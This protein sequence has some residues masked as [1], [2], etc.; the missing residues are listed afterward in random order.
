R[1]ARVIDLTHAPLAEWGDDHEVRDRVPCFEEHGIRLHCASHGEPPLPDERPTASALPAAR[2][3]SGA[4]L[5]VMTPGGMFTQPLP[6]RGEVVIGRA[7]DCDVAI[8]DAKL[9]RRHLQ[10]RVAEK[11]EVMDLGSTNGTFLR[12]QRLAPNTPHEVVH[13]DMITFGST[14]IVM[15]C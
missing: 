6:E 3:S 15:Q 8:D 7:E 13:G 2:P 11:F 4:T 5:L 10:V 1:V 12:E 14:A 9:S